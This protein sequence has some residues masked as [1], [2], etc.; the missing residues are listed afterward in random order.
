M[1]VKRHNTCI[2]A[3]Y[4]WGSS[5]LGRGSNLAISGDTGFS[6]SNVL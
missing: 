2:L 6:R 4:S 5:D 3:A 1:V